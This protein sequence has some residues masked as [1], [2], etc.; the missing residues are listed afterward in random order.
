MTFDLTMSD[1]WKSSCDIVGVASFFDEEP[2]VIILICFNPHLR[3]S[4]KSQLLCLGC[5]NYLK[6][7]TYLIYKFTM[8]SRPWRDVLLQKRSAA[9]P[10]IG[11]SIVVW[12]AFR[13]ATAVVDA[14]SN[15]PPLQFVAHRN[16]EEKV[17]ISSSYSSC[18]ITECFRFVFWLNNFGSTFAWSVFSTILCHFE[19]YLAMPGL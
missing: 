1:F 11:K 3:C 19:G 4:L 12:N 2:N 18:L 16:D 8:S 7:C 15:S 17:H 14:A 10:A 5:L 6:I 9:K 13:A